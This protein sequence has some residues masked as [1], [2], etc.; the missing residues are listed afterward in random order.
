MKLMQLHLNA[1][2][3]TMIPLG[4]TRLLNIRIFLHP[5]CCAQ[6]HSNETAELFV[7]CK[8]V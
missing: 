4:L 7:T 5:V 8:H 1:K 2:E 3:K 6:S